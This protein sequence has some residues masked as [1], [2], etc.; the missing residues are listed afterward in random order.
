MVFLFF[1]HDNAPA[2]STKAYID[3]LV[4]T[5][6]KLFRQLPYSPDLAICCFVLFPHVK[7]RMKFSHH[8]ET[9]DND[10][11]TM[12]M[13]KSLSKCGTYGWRDVISYDGNYFE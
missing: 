9:S 6:P 11:G 13:L 5:R 8:W 1:Q 2:H 4:T 3:Y 7:I 12:S 10:L